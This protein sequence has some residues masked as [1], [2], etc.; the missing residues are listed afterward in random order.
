[1]PT[2]FHEAAGLI[3]GFATYRRVIP[4]A[5]GDLDIA[6]GLARQMLSAR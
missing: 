2:V 4:S 1:V 3:H 6:L 5:Q